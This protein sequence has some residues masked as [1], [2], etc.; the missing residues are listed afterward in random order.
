MEEME[1]LRMLFD[2]LILL[3]ALYGAF[4]QIEFNCVRK[5]LNQLFQRVTELEMKEKEVDEDGK[6]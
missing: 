5:E 3:V 1:R 2:V 6:Y 4:A